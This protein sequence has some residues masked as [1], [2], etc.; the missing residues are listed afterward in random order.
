MRRGG[1]VLGLASH[2][3]PKH[4]QLRLNSI[5]QWSL[6]RL[7]LL[8]GAVAPPP[9]QLHGLSPALTLPVCSDLPWY[10]MVAIGAVLGAAVIGLGEAI[11]FVS[12]PRSAF[13]GPPSTAAL[14]L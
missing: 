4:P 7:F 5:P 11:W 6:P 13:L 9:S 1:L 10:W 12:H 8:A 3:Q 2:R 14:H